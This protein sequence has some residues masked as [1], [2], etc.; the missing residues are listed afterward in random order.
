MN[1]NF[2]VFLYRGY[3]K[4]GDCD[5][6][7]HRFLS[8]VVYAMF[9]NATSNMV[10]ILCIIILR[11]IINGLR[12]M[13]WPILFRTPSPQYPTVDFVWTWFC[14]AYARCVCVCVWSAFK[15]GGNLR[16]WQGLRH[17]FRCAQFLCGQQLRKLRHRSDDM[18]GHRVLRHRGK[19]GVSCRV[20]RANSI[21][22]LAQIAHL[23]QMR[24]TL[25]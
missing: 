11:Y 17:S 22:L 2:V 10:R 9:N 15:K 18:S 13:L 16:G 8:C 19:A 21:K 4:T 5:S 14:L 3:T 25:C 6:R 23:S 1:Y 20:G 24:F 12:N 7:P